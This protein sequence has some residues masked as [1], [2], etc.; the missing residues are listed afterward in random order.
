MYFTLRGGLRV[1]ENGVLRKIFGTERE[2]YARA[3]RELCNYQLLV[4]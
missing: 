3:W 4:I 2:E 1:F